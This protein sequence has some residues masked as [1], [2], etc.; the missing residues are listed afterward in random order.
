MKLKVKKDFKGL[1]VGDILEYNENT[2]SYDLFK[3]DFVKSEHGEVTSYQLFTVAAYVAEKLVGDV[4]L[5]LDDQDREFTTV[6]I[7]Y[8]DTKEYQS[9]KELEDLAG[10][11]LGERLDKLEELV[12]QLSK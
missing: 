12:K 11:T 7:R 6:E 10:K 5:T 2:C 3:E 8:C 9:D 1:K 4:F